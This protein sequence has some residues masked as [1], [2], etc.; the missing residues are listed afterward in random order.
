MGMLTITS[1]TPMKRK[2]KAPDAQE[3]TVITDALTDENAVK[4][5]RIEGMKA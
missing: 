1:K 2:K 5:A 3:G 4:K